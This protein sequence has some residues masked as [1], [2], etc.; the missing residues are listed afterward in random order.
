MARIIITGCSGFIGSHLAKYL[1]ERDHFV[2]GIVR[3]GQ[4]VPTHVIPHEIQFEDGKDL[5]R[6]FSEVL[7]DI[8]YHLASPTYK[9]ESN[10]LIDILHH[11]E[12]DIGNLIRLLSVSYKCT[13]SLRA[14]IRVGSLAEYGPTPTP[15]REDHREQPLNIYAA[16]LVA[17]THI[18]QMLR[19]HYKIPFLTARLGLVYGPGQS[20]DFLLPR[21]VANCLKGERTIIVHPNYRRDMIAIEDIVKAL[22]ILGESPPQDISIL[23]LSTGVAP[24]V[25]DIAAIVIEKTCC[26]STLVE[27]QKSLNS[28]EIKDLRGSSELMQKKTG[29]RAQIPISEGV[30]RL[31][32][33]YLEQNK[34]SNL[35]VL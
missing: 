25:M 7:P 11:L 34:N 9:N 4:S 10:D 8:I 23:N 3:K 17:G 28:L 33:W 30:E 27:T 14:F 24:K 19:Q 22:T 1:V 35:N 16:S 29:W 2:H 15:F 5:E 20:E 18:V 6:C 31:V 32:T 13:P 21:L 12:T 26:D